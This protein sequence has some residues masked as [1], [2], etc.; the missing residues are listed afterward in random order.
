M[1]GLLLGLDGPAFGTEGITGLL[2]YALSGEH[3]VLAVIYGKT[4]RKKMQEREKFRSASR[5][6]S[7]RIAASLALS[8][9]VIQLPGIR[10]AVSVNSFHAIVVVA[11]DNIFLFVGFHITR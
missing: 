11:H 4:E 7:L 6:W 1:P 9:D 10:F 5:R 3:L 8:A 2:F